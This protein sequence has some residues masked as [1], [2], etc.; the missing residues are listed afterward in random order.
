MEE[1]EVIEVFEKKISALS[2][3]SMVENLLDERTV[4]R[5]GQ[6]VCYDAKRST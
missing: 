1:L 4:C 5:L 2:I 3:S 6:R